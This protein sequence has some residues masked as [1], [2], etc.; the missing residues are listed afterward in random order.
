M[1][2]AAF[3][4]NDLLRRRLQTS[5]TIATLTLSVAST[6]FLLLFSSRLGFG[7]T[8]ATSIFTDGN[9]RAVFTVYTFHWHTHFCRRRSANFFYRFL[10]DVSKNPRFRLDKGSW[11]PKQ[12]CCWILHDRTTNNNGSRMRFRRNCWLFNGLWRR[13][14]CFFIL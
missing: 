2:K 1:S 9:N 11:M 12:P 4:I 8:S 10:Y 5:L 13:K 6:L 7:L 3:P 14:L